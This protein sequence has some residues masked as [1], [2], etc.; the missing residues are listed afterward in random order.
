MSWVIPK[1]NWAGAD[2][3]SEVDMNRIEGNIADIK[4]KMI[5]DGQTW[6]NMIASRAKGVTYT[7]TTGKAIQVSV[8]WGQASAGGLSLLVNGETMADAYVYN[9]ASAGQL[10]AIIPVGSTYLVVGGN[11]M[12]HFNELR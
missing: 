8:G 6:Q 2:G 5:G 9:Y 7:N 4:S 3:V 11:S 10:T 12:T 1:T